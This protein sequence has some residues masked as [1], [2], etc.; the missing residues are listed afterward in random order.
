M[1]FDSTDTIDVPRSTA[2]PDASE[3]FR[4]QRYIKLVAIVR[5]D[6]NY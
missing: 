6:G 3:A 4:L 1:I 2:A 5:V